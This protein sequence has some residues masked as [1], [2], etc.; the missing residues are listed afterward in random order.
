MDYL[1]SLQGVRWIGRSRPWLLL[2][3]MVIPIG[4]SCR[5]KK[6]PPGNTFLVIN[7]I[8]IKTC[9]VWKL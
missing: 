2:P 9:C 5:R 3:W 8:T 1:L 4:R 6:M 7:L